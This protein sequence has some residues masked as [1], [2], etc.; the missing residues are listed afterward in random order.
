M[1]EG[2]LGSQTVYMSEHSVQKPNHAIRQGTE[3][4]LAMTTSFAYRLRKYSHTTV[5]T[6]LPSNRVNHRNSS[7]DSCR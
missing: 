5:H 3:C 6:P 4:L 2:L 1:A 7:L